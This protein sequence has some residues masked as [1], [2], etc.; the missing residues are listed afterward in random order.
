MT[1]KFDDHPRPASSPSSSD[2]VKLSAFGRTWVVDA[3]R[4][5]P[6]CLR[7]DG[8]LS[9][10]PMVSATFDRV[11][12]RAAALPDAMLPIDTLQIAKALATEPWFG[13]RRLVEQT[14][15]GSL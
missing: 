4:M 12:F 1:T 10:G 11:T 8:S 13:R 7:E 2:G 15:D 14:A 3:E 6:I 5:G 9:L